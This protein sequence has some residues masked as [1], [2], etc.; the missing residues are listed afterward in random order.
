MKTTKDYH[1]SEKISFYYDS[2]NNQLAKSTC[3]CFSVWNAI[4]FT[5]LS[6][7]FKSKQFPRRFF[8]PEVCC[9]VM[10][11]RR[12]EF[13]SER[14]Q[15]LAALVV[16]STVIW[17]QGPFFVKEGVSSPRA[18]VMFHPLSTAVF[19]SPQLRKYFAFA[20]NSCNNSTSQQTLFWIKQ[21]IRWQI[22]T[23]GNS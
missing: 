21:L 9:L 22:T 18:M 4:H 16:Y 8:F 1:F 12:N 10:H 7:T 20:T 11:A 3:S 14:G 17:T 5:K 23:V 15:K 2:P 13:E 6:Q 19:L